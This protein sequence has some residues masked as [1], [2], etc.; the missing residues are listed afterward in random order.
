MNLATETY[1]DQARVWPSAGRCILAHYDAETVVVYQA[2][3]RLISNY[4]LKHGVLGGP[5]FSLAR[6][7]WVKPNFLWMMFRCGVGGE[8]KSR[9]G[10]RSSHSARFL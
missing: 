7:S 8:G 10:F 6:M 2:Y 1:R 9:D 4:A 3:N 5:H